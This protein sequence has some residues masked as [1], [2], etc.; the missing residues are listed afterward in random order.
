MVEVKG[1]SSGQHEVKSLALDLSQ[2]NMRSGYKLE[3]SL[4]PVLS[5]IAVVPNLFGL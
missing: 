5:S 4:L 3:E 2:N 1:L